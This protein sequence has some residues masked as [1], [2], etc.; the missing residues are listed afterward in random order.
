MAPLG[1]SQRKENRT[2]IKA[3]A[4]SGDENM[5]VDALADA[6]IQE[7]K[8]HMGAQP[9]ANSQRGNTFPLVSWKGK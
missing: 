9:W 4:G 3:P 5:G 7:M 1:V 8:R 6:S 2:T